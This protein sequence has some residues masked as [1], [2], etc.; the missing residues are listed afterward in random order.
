M[1]AFNEENSNLSKCGLI[2]DI[3]QIKAELA[4]LFTIFNINIVDNLSVVNI[5][6]PSK[7]G[8]TSI[9]LTHPI[10]GAD[11]D[12]IILQKITD[13]KSKYFGKLA[14]GHMRLKS[15]GIHS[16]QYTQIGD[17]FKGKY[18]EEMIQQVRA[19][20]INSHP[21]L[22]PISR[23]SCAYLN[24]GPGYCFHK[25]SHTYLK[26]HLPVITN[27]W[28]YMM[29]NADDPT[30]HQLPADGNLWELNTVN[31]HTAFNLSPYKNNYRMHILFDAIRPA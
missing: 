29:T 31:T 1:I 20:H 25:D 30:I 23:I 7:T 13:E 3:A 6:D 4:D 26:Y 14:S 5:I 16:R 12:D 27:P 11:S 24:P 19:Y 2:F 8:H 18:I 21:E 22:P 28:S 9:N 10:I 15:L 17:F